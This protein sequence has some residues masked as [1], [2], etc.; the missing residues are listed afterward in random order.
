MKTQPRTAGSRDGSALIIVMYVCLLLAAIS[1][2]GWK[3]SGTATIRTTRYS[4]HSQARALAEAGVAQMYE[5]VESN[6][7]YWVGRS[8]TNTFGPGHYVASAQ[9][10]SDSVI[11][12]A[13]TGTVEDLSAWTRFEA[14]ATRDYDYVS[15]FTG[16]FAIVTGGDCTIDTGAIN[17]QGNIH[18]NKDIQHTRGNTR[19]D[20]DLSAVG[21]INLTPY[22]AH[23]ATT[24]APSAGLPKLYPFTPWK[25]LAQDGGTYF[26]TSQIFSK[27]TFTPANGVIYVEGDVLVEN[28]TDLVGTLVVTGNIIIENRFTQTAF[29]TNRP[30]LMA[31]GDILLYNRNEY[32]GL[33]YT[34]GNF[35]S[36][37]NKQIDGMVM[38][39]G[40]AVVENNCDIIP[41]GEQYDLFPGEPQPEGDVVEAG[42]WVE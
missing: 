28:R 27:D 11:D 40:N 9:W 31:G 2:V 38:A 32:R 25:K 36:H 6:N 42:G 34:G 37:N 33:I 26:S 17:V 16:M 1:T 7:Y 19:V 41:T 22:A 18:A 3:L 29:T 15:F 39:L 35:V 4:R 20:G 30:C 10:L 14:L 12:I 8:I 5:N 21:D 13:S 23:T 24:N